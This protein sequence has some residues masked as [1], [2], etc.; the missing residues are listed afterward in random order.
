MASNTGDG[1]YYPNVIKGK[2]I[3]ACFYAGFIPGLIAPFLGS[4]VSGRGIYK[5]QTASLFKEL[6]T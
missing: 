4:L 1:I 3:P 6:E 5:R 2:I